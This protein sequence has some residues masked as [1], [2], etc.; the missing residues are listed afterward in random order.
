[1][2]GIRDVAPSNYIREHDIDAREWDDEA[3]L[4]RDLEQTLE[5]DFAKF[6]QDFAA[7]EKTAHR[8][9][10]QKVPGNKST[11]KHTTGHTSKTAKG[12]HSTSKTTVPHSK[13]VHHKSTT[14]KHKSSHLN[15]AGGK[16]TKLPNG[17]TSTTPKGLTAGKTLTTKGP[18]SKTI[19]KTTSKGLQPGKT[20]D[21]LVSQPPKSP[22]SK[23]E[24]TVMQDFA[25]LQKDFASE[26]KVPVSKSVMTSKPSSVS[27]NL[28][29]PVTAPNT[30]AASVK[31]VKREFD[32]ELFDREYDE[33]LFERDYDDDDV[34]VRD[35]D[36]DIF[37]CVVFSSLQLFLNLNSST[38]SSFRREYIIDELD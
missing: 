37:E 24:S 5:Q 33:E 10:S 4:T 32:E 19:S 25:K 7:E 34:F 11:T 18:L 27:A 21:K 13:T 14:E 20:M 29:A 26:K 15:A 3:L 1:M 9:A 8:S 38:L 16:S 6:Q 23:T 30:P 35:Y 31:K 17:R 22:Q 36:E 28:K 2:H 12:L